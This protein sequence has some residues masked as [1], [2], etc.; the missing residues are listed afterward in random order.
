MKRILAC[1]YWSALLLGLATGMP[2]KAGAALVA[3]DQFLSGH[4]GQA[5]L[6]LDQ[7]MLLNRWPKQG[8]CGAPAS[9]VCSASV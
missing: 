9:S 5:I 7:V 4:G 6:P 2:Q 1:C 3:E 8:A